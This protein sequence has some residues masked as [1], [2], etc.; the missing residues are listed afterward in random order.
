MLFL[1]R[2]WFYTQSEGGANTTTI[3]SPKKTCCSNNDALQKRGSNRLL[4]G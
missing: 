3:S 4:P 2:I 1:Q